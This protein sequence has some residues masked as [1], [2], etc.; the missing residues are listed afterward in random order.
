MR[1]TLS[2]GARE[3]LD[4]YLLAREMTFTKNVC[5]VPG[6]VLFVYAPYETAAYALGEIAVF[7]PL[8]EVRPLLHEGL[9]LPA[10]RVS[11]GVVKR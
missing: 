3:R 11:T 8:A 7:V 10:R 5:L 6:G 1:R 4:K 2:S 9:P